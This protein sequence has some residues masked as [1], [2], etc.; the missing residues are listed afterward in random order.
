[1]SYFDD[2][3][4]R[5]AWEK[6]LA[7]LKAEKEALK[8]V[9]PEAR[10]AVAKSIEKA[11]NDTP[12]RERITYAQLL[13]EESMAIQAKKNRVAERTLEKEASFEM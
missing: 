6:E 12:T 11:M 10:A 7:A 2:P 4:K 5:A 9:P 8:S 1:M 13:M 3:K